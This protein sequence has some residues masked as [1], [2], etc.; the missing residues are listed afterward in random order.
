MARSISFH[1]LSSARR[2]CVT[3]VVTERRAANH[4]EHSQRS[5]LCSRR[6]DN[7]SAVFGAVNIGDPG[8]HRKV[9]SVAQFG[10]PE[11]RCDRYLPLDHALHRFVHGNT[12]RPRRLVGKLTSTEL[13]ECMAGGE[14]A[15][16]NIPTRGNS[17]CIGCCPATLSAP[18]S[19]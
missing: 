12:D 3:R 16:I 18:S 11:G 8:S 15:P 7:V 1:V 2:R 19:L 4:F 5:T 10:A 6:G 17:G 14:D 13:G 9:V